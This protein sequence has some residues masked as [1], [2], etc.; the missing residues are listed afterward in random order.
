MTIIKCL[1]CGQQKEHHAKGY[2]EY[3]Y[4]K[5]IWRP[6]SIICKRCQREMPL[7]A[8]GLCRGCYNFVFHLEDNKALNYKKWHNIE[9]ELYKKIT[10]RCVV[11]GFDKVVDLHHLNQNKGDNSEKN[12]I[13]L[14][15]NHHK[16][17]H[18]YNFREEMFNAL[19]EKGYEPPKDIKLGYFKK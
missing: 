12:L 16:M 13:G 6:K 18:N 7:Q 11:C 2:C 10:Q 17:I 19:K 9:P 14:C 4:K 3:C 15:P 5:F 1:K 8:K